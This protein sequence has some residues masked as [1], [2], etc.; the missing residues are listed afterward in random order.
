MGTQS[1]ATAVATAAY[2]RPAFSAP[3]APVQADRR[4]SRRYPINLTACCEIR[5]TFGKLVSSTA[6]VV[7]ISSGGIL[8]YSEHPLEAG[9]KIRVRIDWPALLHGVVPLALHV[10]GHTLRIERNYVAVKVL[11]SEF[12]TRSAGQPAAAPHSGP[13]PVR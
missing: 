5:N 1:Q 13:R 2:A 3:V 9:L 10:D 11:K 7:N 8:I 4:S 6:R 12:R